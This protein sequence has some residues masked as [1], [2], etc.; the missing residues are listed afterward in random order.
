MKELIPKLPNG[1]N[2]G[3]IDHPFAKLRDLFWNHTILLI[4][5][6]FVLY[7]E[8]QLGSSET[9]FSKGTPECFHL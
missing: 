9:I 7:P 6:N 3:W 8:Q 2:G 1:S 4:S 5:S